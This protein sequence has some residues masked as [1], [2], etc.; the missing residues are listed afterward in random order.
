MKLRPL[1]LLL[2]TVVLGAGC[3]VQHDAG[4]PGDALNS[5]DNSGYASITFDWTFDGRSC[6]D[7][8]VQTVVVSMPGEL[9]QNNGSYPCSTGGQ[10]GITLEDF[11]PGTYPYVI[12]G[13]DGWGNLV[14]EGTGQVDVGDSNQVERVN[15]VSMNNAPKPPGEPDAGVF[16][17][18]NDGFDAGTGGFDGGSDHFDAGTGDFDA[19]TGGNDGGTGTA[20]AGTGQHPWDAGSG[21]YAY[22]L[23]WT[24]PDAGNAPVCGEELSQVVMTIDGQSSTYDCTAGLSP[25]H[26]TTPPLSLGTHAIRLDAEDDGGTVWASTQA[27]LDVTCGCH[28]TLTYQLPWVVGS[29]AVDWI[30]FDQNHQNP[31]TD[32]TT[33]GVDTMAANFQDGAG[34][35][36]FADAQGGPADNT[37]SCVDSGGIE[38]YRAL[39]PGDYS[40]Y[41]AGHGSCSTYYEYPGQDCYQVTVQAGVFLTQDTAAPS[42]VSID[43]DAQPQP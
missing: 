42:A 9:L 2:A 5:G 17:G 35:W 25:A 1:P 18:G 22:N 20:D 26:V 23:S 12:D 14:Y 43:L 10:E 8:Y 11:F 38:V 13:Y 39:P 6:A 4:S 31:T 34:N 32:C 24:F 16:D 15:L 27:S 36:L 30:F 19:G 41:L 40:V 37:F 7:A 29:A 33:A 28:S 3:I 21:P